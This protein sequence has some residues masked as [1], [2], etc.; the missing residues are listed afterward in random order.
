MREG[1]LIERIRNLEK[2]PGR[3]TT[4]DPKK[5]IASILQHLTKVL[6]TRRGGAQIADD[7]GLPD[8]TDYLHDYSTGLR[9]VEKSIR[10]T[11]RKYEPRLKSVRVKFIPQE[12][13]VLSLCFQVSAR[14]AEVHGDHPVIFESLVGSGGQIRIR[15]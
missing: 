2:D 12:E 7:F 8:L 4:E 11:I 6:N 15:G 13:D 5:V 3:S 9:E 10:E 14:L 1:R